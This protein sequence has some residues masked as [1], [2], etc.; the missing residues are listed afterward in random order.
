MVF[1]EIGSGQVIIGGVLSEDWLKVTV[2][3]HSAVSPAASF[4]SKVF[5]VVPTGNSA[6]DAS[7][8]FWVIV[9]EQLSEKVGGL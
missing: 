7:P 1:L 8:A 6:P 5:V 2:K 4:T 3:L 9:A